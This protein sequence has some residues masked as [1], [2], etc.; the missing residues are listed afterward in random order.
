MD[1]T[2]YLCYGDSI[3][4][5]VPGVTY[6]SYMSQY[7]DF[8][9]H[10]LGGDTL[11]GVTKRIMDGIKAEDCPNYIVQIGTNDVL[12]PHLKSL[13]AA[14]EKQ[15]GGLIKRG[16]VPCK[17]AKEFEERYDQLLTTLKEHHKNVKVINIPCVGEDVTSEPN[18]KVDAY[19]AVID[20]L[21]N[22]HGID[23]I[24][25]NRWQKTML[26][27]HDTDGAY[28]ITANPMNM[29]L[30]SITT[31]HK[32]VCARLSKKRGLRI[33]VDGCHLNAQGAEGMAKLVKEKL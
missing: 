12:L 28:F 2:Q 1:K 7:G 3:T 11:I 22:A 25:F 10:G 32:P 27:G 15:V 18:K 19:N 20:R 14:W 26:Q 5:G 17:D 6:L 31:T 16:S 24:D 9:N 21:A 13:S 4:K 8:K 29:I 30:D 23:H 33:T